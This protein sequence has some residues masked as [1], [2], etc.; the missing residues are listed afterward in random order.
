MTT[1]QLSSGLY[2]IAV[3]R[4]SGGIAG[5]LLTRQGKDR[6]TI[7]PPS[8]KPDPDQ[9]VIRRFLTSSIVCRSPALLVENHPWSRG[10]HHHL[11]PLPDLS[12]LLPYL[13]RRSR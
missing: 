5:G 1:T 10:Q 6:V 8:A 7:L 9:E 12:K 4:A 3:A 2:R 13:Q 11:N